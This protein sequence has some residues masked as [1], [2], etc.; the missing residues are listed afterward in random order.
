[1]LCKLSLGGEMNGDTRIEIIR[2]GHIIIVVGAVDIIQVSILDM[3]VIGTVED[4]QGQLL[5]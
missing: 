2:I 3:E 1:M 4:D 5:P